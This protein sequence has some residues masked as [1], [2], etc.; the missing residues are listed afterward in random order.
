F[1]SPPSIGE[2]YRSDP[3]RVKQVLL[4]IIGNAVKF[5]K[6]GTV[7]VQ[8][9]VAPIAGGSEA[10]TS[11][12]ALRVVVIDQGVGMT[13]KQAERLFRPFG[14]ADASVARQFGGSG[15]GLV[16]SKQ[17]AKTL[18]GDIKLLR[19]QPGE[20]STFEIKIKLE[21]AQAD[22]SVEAETTA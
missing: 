20:G 22:A 11:F 17:I 13:A 7:E 6:E 18:G 5:T 10:G 3:T 15:L 1:S 14:Q 12:D 16:I 8:V 4:N 21:K 19:S 2:V 9:E